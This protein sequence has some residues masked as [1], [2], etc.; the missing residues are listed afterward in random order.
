VVVASEPVVFKPHS[1]ALSKS[2]RWLEKLGMPWFLA[3]LFGIG[4]TGLMDR[5]TPL[6]VDFLVLVIAAAPVAVC[7]ISSWLGRLPGFRWLHERIQPRVAIGP[8]GLVVQLPSTGKRF[9]SW[10]EITGLRTKHGRGADLLGPDGIV[11][12]N[13]PESLVLAGGNWWRAESIASVVVRFRPDLYS[14]SG[15]NWA[16]VPNAFALRGPE[17]TEDPDLNTERWLHRQRTRDRAVMVVAIAG[18]VVILAW[19]AIRQ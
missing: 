16:G 6:L 12:A 13:I 9:H 5:S 1:P 2:G 7:L 19:T 4:A 14:L 11:L 15:A 8:D 3:V 17:D 18:I 10:E